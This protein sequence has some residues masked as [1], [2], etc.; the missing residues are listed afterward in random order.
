MRPRDH[1][2]PVE[3][4]TLVQREGLSLRDRLVLRILAETGLRRRAVAW[5][6]VRG[7]IGCAHP[8]PWDEGP[9]QPRAVCIATEKGLVTRPFVLSEGKRTLLRQYLCSKRHPINRPHRGCFRA[10]VIRSGPW[11]HPR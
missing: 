5:L 3:V 7:M 11:P 8:S 2:T 9:S 4:Q 6:T 10:G 1:F